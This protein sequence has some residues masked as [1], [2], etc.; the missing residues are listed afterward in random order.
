V[1][2]YL[3]KDYAGF[4]QSLLDFIPTRMPSWTERSEADIGMVL[5]ELFAAT[6]DTLSYTQDR[7]ANEAFLDTALQRRSVAAHLAL[8]G[9]EMDQGAAASTWLRFRLWDDAPPVALEAGSRVTNKPTRANEP[10]VVFETDAEATLRPDHN[11]FDVFMWGRSECCLP[12]TALS[13]ELAGRHPTLQAGDYLDLDDLR[14]SHDVVRLTRVTPTPPAATPAYTR[15]EW[16]PA[17]PLS[18]GYRVRADGDPRLVVRGN[19]V[20]A[21]HGETVTEE[22][23]AVLGPDERENARR[24]G[25][26]LRLRH[27]PLAYH[28]AGPAAEAFPLRGARGTSTLKLTVGDDPWEERPTLLESGPNGRHFRVEIDDAGEATV[29]F[30]KPGLESGAAPPKG[31]TVKATYRVGGGAAGNV[32][33]GTL[34]QVRRPDNPAALGIESVTNPLPAAGGRDRESR[35]RARRFAPATF[36]RPLV[37]LTAE[38]F[39]AFAQGYAGGT[40]VQRAR[41]DFRWTGSWLTATVAIDPLGSPTPDPAL[42]AEVFA[43]LDARRLAGYDLEVTRAG[44]APVE[45]V[46]DLIPGPGVRAGELV[47]AAEAALGTAALPGGRTGLFHPDNFTFGQSLYV[48]QIYNAVAGVPGLRAAHIARL[49]RFG[50]ADFEAQTAANLKRGFLP[51]RADEIVRLDNDRNFPENGTLLVRV[52]EAGA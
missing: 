37:A 43:L 41:A 6:A 36:K 12:A 19:L 18:R 46:V 38:Q 10:L 50:A 40:R 51:V 22:T 49:S 5:L 39:E 25:R 24:L 31:A 30:G 14:G 2:D 17:T 48:G 29:R 27:G 52:P 26:G 35:D 15:V 11:Q 21:T 23:L 9:Y 42:R 20:P 3:V 13:L 4:R 8:I 45:L 34:T 44:Y 32:A 28:P 16:S 7:V 47:R 1:V 33:A